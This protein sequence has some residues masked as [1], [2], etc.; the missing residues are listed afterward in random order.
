MDHC[1]WSI[2]LRQNIDCLHVSPG[3]PGRDFELIVYRCR[4]FRFYR[5]CVI[6]AVSAVRRVTVLLASLL[7]SVIPTVSAVHLVTMLLASLLLSVI[8]A[9]SAVHL[10]TVLLASLLLSVIPAVSAVHLVTVLFSPL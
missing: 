5:E 3:S 2:L 7:L 1:G 4:L 8:P 9:V 10:V 6:P